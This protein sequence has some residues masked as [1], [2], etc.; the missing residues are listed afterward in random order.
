[1]QSITIKGFFAQILV[2][3]LFAIKKYTQAFSCAYIELWMHLR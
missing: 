1:M 2:V 3:A